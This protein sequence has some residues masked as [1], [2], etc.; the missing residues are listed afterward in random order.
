MMITFHH[1]QQI[2]L[3][4]EVL[5]Q[6]PISLKGTGPGTIPLMSRRTPS[7][8]TCPPRSLS[9]RTTPDPGVGVVNDRCDEE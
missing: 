9:R 6:R 5:A 2:Y 8:Q 1:L 7:S 4:Q 3:D